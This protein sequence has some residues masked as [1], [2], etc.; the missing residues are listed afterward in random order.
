MDSRLRG[1]EGKRCPSLSGIFIN[2]SPISP[3]LIPA[4]AGIQTILNIRI[5]TLITRRRLITEQPKAPKGEEEF[6][7]EC[8]IKN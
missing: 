8:R 5:N 7:V 6:N 4:K 1:N 2:R 3:P